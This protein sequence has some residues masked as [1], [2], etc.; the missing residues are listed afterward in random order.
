MKRDEFRK[1]TDSRLVILDGAT[2]TELLRA[3][4]PTE[5]CPEK[6][7]LEHPDVLID[8]QRAYAEAG[9]DIVYACTFGANR[10]RLR[11][12]GIAS[13]VVEMNQELVALSRKAVGNRLVF[14]DIAPSGTFV[15]PLG[16]VPFGEAV[17][18]CRQQVRG[19]L[20]GGVDGFTVE[21]MVDIQEARAAII[22]IREMC[23][24]PVMV[25][26]TLDH[27]GRAL[28][29]A[30]LLN[31]VI[32]LQALGAD[33]VGCNCSTGPADLVPSI[34]EAKSSAAVPLLA[35]PN[36]GMP[37]GEGKSIEFD[38]DADE[39]ASYVPEF[40]RRGVNLLGGC[41][42][43]NP[44]YIR[45][46]RERAES[47]KVKP[48]KVEAVSALT[49]SRSTVFMGID[50]PLTIIGERINPTGKKKL[51]AQLQEE[52]LDLV[53]KLAIEQTER[54]AA[55]LDVN[56]GLADIDQ[57]K[58]M[59]RAVETLSQLTAAPL[60]IDTTD[61]EVLEEALRVY[62][63]RA[64]VNSISAEKERLEINLPIAAKY[65]AMII[66][67]P[68]SQGCMP[69]DVPSR[70]KAAEQVLEAAS[71]HGYRSEDVVID[72]FM[73]AASSHPEAASQTLETIEWITR[74]IGANSV[75]GLSNVSFG[76]PGREWLNASFL[77]MAVGRGLTSVIANPKDRLVMASKYTA[78]ALWG[79]DEYCM[80]YLR[81]YRA[82]LQRHAVVHRGG[83]E[84]Y[85]K[86]Y[87]DDNEVAIETLENPEEV[88]EDAL[89][90]RV[91][92]AGLLG[93]E[94]PQE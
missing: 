47:C 50:R 60:C 35:K 63:G 48:P 75:I 56:V 89:S 85:Q 71:S 80:E 38:I 79:R 69:L 43:T 94:D 25:S 45:K 22:A 73:L 15:A 11:R 6:W 1:L 52:K 41:C 86:M 21:T 87:A 68:M 44:E 18:V 5:A 2:G 91:G 74:E 42:G 59:R 8:L 30:D 4:M 54:G 36:A 23:D 67:L 34:R 28:V 49:S 39:F 17:E 78:D 19:L 9:S 57:V 61:P 3:G 81:Y 14:G 16:D 7:V 77:S 24:L 33:A 70:I 92:E 84:E 12:Y 37:I 90:R 72:A 46:I 83:P 20:K 88:V 93:A 13:D 64:L 58:M 10:F 27:S 31:A 51:R 26:M 29:G 82:I 65:G 32:V 55:L 66:V 53:R 62:P 76:L 40:A